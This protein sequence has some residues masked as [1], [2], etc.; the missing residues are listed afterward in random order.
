MAVKTLEETLAQ[1]SAD[2][3]K[4]FESTLSKHQEL[5]DGWLRQDDY[6]RKMT[7]ISA[8]QKTFDEN[9]AQMKQWQEWSDKTVPIWDHLVEVGVVDKETFEE[10]WSKKQQEYETKLK[11]AESRAIAGA[12]MKPEEIDAHVKKIIADSGG[13]ATKADYDALV[14]NEA[15][16]IAEEVFNSEFSKQETKFNENTVPMVVGMSGANAILAMHYEAETGEKWNTEKQKEL[17]AQMVRNR[18]Y[19][20]FANEEE[21]LKPHRDKKARA[22]EIEDEVAKRVAA[23]R[24]Q[25]AE[26]GGREDYIPQVGDQKGALKQMLER[27]AG[28]DDF[29]AII[30]EQAKKAGGELRTEGKA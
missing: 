13:F 5:K 19:D 3:R 30:A 15:K 16:K 26:T 17:F 11:E 29:Q 7:E 23:E 24:S 1:L 12:D 18:N 22:K 28:S 14:K 20:P 27:S 25:R 21:F 8:R 10:T 6:S 4:L 9:A 2:E